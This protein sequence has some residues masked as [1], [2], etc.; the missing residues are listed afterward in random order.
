METKIEENTPARSAT[1]IILALLCG[2]IALAFCFTIIFGIGTGMAISNTP[3]SGTREYL[4]QWAIFYCGGTLF[5][6][7]IPYLAYSYGMMLGQWISGCPPGP[8]SRPDPE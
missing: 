1:A 4:L 8:A 6:L 3:W 7:Y 5:V 2:G